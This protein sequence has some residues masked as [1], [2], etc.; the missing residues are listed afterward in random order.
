MQCT[1][2]MRL[3]M[4]QCGQFINGFNDEIW[5]VVN[6]FTS[7]GQVRTENDSNLTVFLIEDILCNV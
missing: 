5:N 7:K 4:V 2:D 1:P 3:R 6:K